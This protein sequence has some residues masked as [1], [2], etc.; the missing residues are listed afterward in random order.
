MKRMSVWVLAAALGLMA[1]CRHVEN[2]P[3][4]N[5]FHNAGGGDVDRS[6]PEAISQFLIQRDDV[7]K[8]LTPLCAQRKANAPAE[9]STTDEGK[10][11][12]GNTLANAF[13]KSNMKSDGVRF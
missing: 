6:T 10:V 11:C 9:W 3:I 13:G 7:R 2:S 5:T 12:A 1:G 4:V 8:Q